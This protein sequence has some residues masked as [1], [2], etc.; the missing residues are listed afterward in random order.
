MI[1]N[2]CYLCGRKIIGIRYCWLLVFYNLE[3]LVPLCQE[4]NL[5]VDK[6]II[7]NLDYFYKVAKK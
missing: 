6:Q 4:C 3:N 7:D 5:S 2:K 1:K